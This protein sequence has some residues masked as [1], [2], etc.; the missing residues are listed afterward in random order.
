MPQK[1][2][3]LPHICFFSYR[4]VSLAQIL[5]VHNVVFSRQPRQQKI[6]KTLIK[7]Y[8]HFACIFYTVQKEGHFDGQCVQYHY[9]KSY[10]TKHKHFLIY[11]EIFFPF[12]TL[13]PITPPPPKFP[14]YEEKFSELFLIS[15]AQYQC[16][17]LCFTFSFRCFCFFVYKYI[18]NK[19]SENICPIFQGNYNQQKSFLKYSTYIPLFFSVKAG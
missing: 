6:I 5:P 17:K 12:L 14:I 13:Y 16:D 8:E 11:A 7:Q 18:N 3:A 10:I 9:N 19:K 2:C 4:L 15:A 1:M